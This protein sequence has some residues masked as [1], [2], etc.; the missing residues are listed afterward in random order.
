MCVWHA[1]YSAC[2]YLYV[3]THVSCIYYTYKYLCVCD[4]AGV[5]VHTYECISHFGIWG[6]PF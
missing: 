1:P 4:Y 2:V 5:S 3:S 6:A